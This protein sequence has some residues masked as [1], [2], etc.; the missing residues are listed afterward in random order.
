MITL[1]LTSTCPRCKDR[2]IITLKRKEQFKFRHRVECPK[3]QESYT[4]LN[5]LSKTTKQILKKVHGGKI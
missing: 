2:H 4:W 5:S 1:I 3:C